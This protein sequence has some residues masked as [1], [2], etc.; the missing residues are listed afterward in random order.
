MIFI[1]PFNSYTKLIHENHYN[2]NSLLNLEF[3]IDLKQ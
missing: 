3:K 2:L 1:Q